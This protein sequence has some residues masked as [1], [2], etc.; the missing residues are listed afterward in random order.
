MKQP[1]HTAAA[2]ALVCPDD[3]VAVVAVAIRWGGLG[4]IAPVVGID[5]GMP[6]VAYVAREYA[7]AAA[8]VP[9]D[10]RES[11]PAAAVAVAAAADSACT[12]TVGELAANAAVVAA[13]A[14]VERRGVP[15][16][17]C[18]AHHHAR[19]PRHA[20]AARHWTA[21][22][23][24]APGRLVALAVGSG[25]LL[26]DVISHL[27]P[28]FQVRTAVARVSRAR[29][30][31]PVPEQHHGHDDGG[32]RHHR[33]H[34]LLDAAAPL[35]STWH[36]CRTPYFAVFVRH[37]GRRLVL[38]VYL[39][40]CRLCLALRP[41]GLVEVCSCL[42]TTYYSHNRPMPASRSVALAGLIWSAN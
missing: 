41:P 31:L 11:A 18:I 13:A 14:A 16:P 27:V 6:R 21:P 9:D 30:L 10:A 8:P 3:D 34:Q 5:D 29:L 28:D 22:R 35:Q 36:C 23:D 2:A 37:L 15:G 32:R 25:Q 17:D 4:D 26:V 33:F 39:G 1:L 24:G 7:E 20:H 19:V 12:D 40:L 38:L 42:W